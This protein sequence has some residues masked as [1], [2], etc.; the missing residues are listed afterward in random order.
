MSDTLDEPSEP[1][2]RRT[3]DK[4]GSPATIPRYRANDQQ[5]AS[6]LLFQDDPGCQTPS[7]R[8]AEIGLNQLCSCALIVLQFSL[9]TESAIGEKKDIKPAERFN[10]FIELRRRN[11]VCSVEQP[12]CRVVGAAH[13]QVGRDFIKP[14]RVAAYENQSS[15][16]RSPNSGSQFCDGRCRTKNNYSFCPSAHCDTL[17]QKS[18]LITGSFRSFCHRGNERRNISL[19][20]RPSLAG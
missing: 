18:E 10:H 1:S 17:C 4:I 20:M 15:S 7:Y 19:D 8:A 2:L 3:V 14:S 5:C 6:A 11:S 12:C 13:L 9:M 16:L